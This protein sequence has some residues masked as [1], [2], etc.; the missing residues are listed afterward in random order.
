MLTV[1]VDNCLQTFS[2]TSGEIGN[3]AIA[4]GDCEVKRN[5]F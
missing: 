4:G 5:L 1:A 2:E 3:Q